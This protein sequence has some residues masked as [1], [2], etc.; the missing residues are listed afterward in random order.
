MYC[1]VLLDMDIVSSASN[2]KATVSVTAESPKTGDMILCKMPQVSD[3]HL[4]GL[5]F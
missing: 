5:L 4:Y 3:H 2:Y 1:D